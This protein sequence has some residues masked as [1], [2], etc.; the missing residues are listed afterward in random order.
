[1]SF[2]LVG[3]KMFL[4][5]WQLESFVLGGSKAL[6]FCNALGGSALRLGM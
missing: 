1:M 4:G 2:G 5:G 3:V 6:I